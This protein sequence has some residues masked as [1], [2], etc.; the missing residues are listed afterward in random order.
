M[1][2]W[3]VAV[4]HTINNMP[5]PSWIDGNDKDYTNWGNEQPDRDGDHQCAF[6]EGDVGSGK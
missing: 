3:W 4:T 5:Y 6:S 1:L 2:T